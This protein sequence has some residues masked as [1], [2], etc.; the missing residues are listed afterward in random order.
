M[1][2]SMRL[3][4]IGSGD[5]FSS[6][7]RL[8]TC[9]HVRTG[10]GAFLIDCGATVLVGLKRH[11]VDPD[12]IDTIY[13]THLHGDHFAGLVWFLMYAFYV[14]RRTAPLTIAGPEGIEARVKAASEALFPGSYNVSRRHPLTYVEYRLDTPMR[15]GEALVTAREVSHPSGAPSCALRLEVAGRTLAYSGDTEWTENLIRCGEGADLYITECYAFDKPVRY[16]LDWKTLQP[17]LARIGAKRILI[18]HMNED[19]LAQ[20]TLLAAAG[21]LAAEDGLTLDV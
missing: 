14:T 8:Q 1:G 11:Q 20:R 7:A 19:M 18:T 9:F 3:T 10:K 5:A 13:I 12:T 2:E 16:H 17:N 4:L 15:I 21:V 6:G